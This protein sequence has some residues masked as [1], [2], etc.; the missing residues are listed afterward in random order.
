MSPIS[1]QRCENS[2][3]ETLGFQ[4]WISTFAVG[5][6]LEAKWNT[7]LVWLMSS[8]HSYEYDNHPTRIISCWI[9]TSVLNVIFRSSSNLISIP[10]HSFSNDL[11]DPSVMCLGSSCYS[12]CCDRNDNSLYPIKFQLAFAPSNPFI[13]NCQAVQKQMGIHFPTPQI[14]QTFCAQRYFYH[15]NEFQRFHRA[16]IHS[17]EPC[18]MDEKSNKKIPTKHAPCCSQWHSKDQARWSVSQ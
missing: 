1:N 8:S 11:W 4:F 7:P 18:Q 16:L 15:D 10:L 9:W 3:T 6:A 5:S 12:S 14:S 13:V 17:K 2:S